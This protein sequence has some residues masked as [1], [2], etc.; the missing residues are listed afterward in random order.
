MKIFVAHSSDFDFKNELYRPI[1]ESKIN[2]EHEFILP[3]ENG[4]ESTTKEIIK[5]CD[6][7]VAEGSLPSTGLGVELGWA[8]VFS[9]P[10][11]CFHRRNKKISN[12]FNKLTE[13]IIAYEDKD[14]L[15]SKLA[16]FLLTTK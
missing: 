13:N 16:R 15:I 3:Q 8:N 4:E 5:S 11:V 9:I 7:I 2:N 6:L 12:S 14:D 10:I 1:R